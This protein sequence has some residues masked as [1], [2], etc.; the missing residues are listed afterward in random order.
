MYCALSRPMV[1]HSMLPTMG[2]V[3]TVEEPVE[4][5][6]DEPESETVEVAVDET[7]LDALEVP[8]LVCVVD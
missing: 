8:E 5:S 1:A 3:V 7:E 4:V 6:V 2:A